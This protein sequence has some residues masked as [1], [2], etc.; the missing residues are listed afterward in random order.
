MP[1]KLRKMTAD[2]YEIF[3]RWSVEQQTAELMAQF[4]KNR[5]EA[6]RETVEEVGQMLPNGL[7]TENNHLLSVVERASGEVAGFI[8]TVHE[9]TGGRKQSFV[10]DFAIWEPK[11]RKGYGAAALRLAEQ[12]AAEAGCQ[13]SVLF[14]AD[15]N[16]AA[17]ALYEK[18]G[19]KVLRSEGRGTYMVKKLP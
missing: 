8:W 3:Y 10:C 18:S 15:V 12:Y 17:K 4:G 13:E 19:Y 14:V 9:E 7:H 11:R 5:E 16:T 1:V 2:E 6:L